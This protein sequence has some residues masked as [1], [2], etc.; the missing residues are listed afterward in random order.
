M[1]QPMLALF[2]E[3]DALVLPEPNRTRLERYFGAAQGDTQ[4][5][6]VTAPGANHFFRASARCAEPGGYAEWAEGFFEALGHPG[7]WNHISA[8]SAADSPAPAHVADLAPA[9]R[10]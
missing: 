3:Q 6:V 5:V 7:F 9:L 4:L 8:S 2:A 10:R 1:R